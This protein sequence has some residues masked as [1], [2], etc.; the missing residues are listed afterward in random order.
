MTRTSVL[1]TAIAALLA[2]GTATASAQSKGPTGVW[3]NQEKSTA[4]RVQ[5]C[6]KSLCGSVTWL[7]EPLNKAGQPKVDREN[8]DP[9]LRNR[10]L[11]GLP[12]LL[13]MKP[14]GQNRWSGRIYNADDGRTYVSH[15]E[16]ASANQMQVQG[17]VLGGLI[18]RKMNWTRDTDGRFA[19]N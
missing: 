2:A 19:K 14:D 15:I 1:L 7:R 13:N 17:C 18:C 16:M 5:R 10:R 12:V 4:V 9:K 8:P 11:L 3:V 6:G